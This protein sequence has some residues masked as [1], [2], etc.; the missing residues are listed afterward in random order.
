MLNHNIIQGEMLPNSGPA[1][2][3][4][5]ANNVIIGTN[6]WIQAE[7]ATMDAYGNTVYSNAVLTIP[8]PWN[9]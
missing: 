4:Y 2:T 7:P 6:N 5:F 8:S 1:M 9:D 3:Q